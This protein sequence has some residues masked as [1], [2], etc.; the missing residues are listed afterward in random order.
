KLKVFV[1]K[2]TLLERL[3][4]KIDLLREPSSDSSNDGNLSPAEIQARKVHDAGMERILVFARSLGSDLMRMMDD[5]LSTYTRLEDQLESD[6]REDENVRSFFYACIS[7]LGEKG[8]RQII[9]KC[10]AACRDA[11]IEERSAIYKQVVESLA[12]T[13]RNVAEKIHSLA[14]KKARALLKQE[15]FNHA[16]SE[17][18]SALHLWRDDPDTYRLLATIL[19]TKGDDRGALVALREVLRL[20]PDDLSLRKRIAKLCEKFGEKDQAIT[21]YEEVIA[22][23]P[24]DYKILQK[25]SVLLFDKGNFSRVTQALP[26]YVRLFPEDIESQFRL[27]VSWHHVGQPQKAIPLLRRVVDSSSDRREAIHFLVLSYRDIEMVDEA[28]ALYE[29]HAETLRDDPRAH[30][31]RGSLYYARGD[32]R[33]TETEFREAI[34]Q[35]GPSYSLLLSLGRSQM[36]Q[37]NLDEAI[38]TL[39][40][41]VNENAGQSELFLELGRALHKQGNYEQAEKVLKQAVQMDENNSA[42]RHELSMVYMASGKWDLAKQML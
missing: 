28:I 8:Q 35:H 7:C 32:L 18:G 22:R 1:D 21:E 29:K 26:D 31:L 30:V 34:N 13:N 10:H 12:K 16:V 19:F 9:E 4:K 36:E 14:R 27:G 24:S 41:A 39:E 25:L 11:R 33:Q 42:I 38:E 15:Q 20:C 3:E 23:A 6:T 5:L 2:K 37:G 40:N 17:L